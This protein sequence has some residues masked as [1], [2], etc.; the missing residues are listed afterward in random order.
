MRLQQKVGRKPA[1]LRKND[2]TTSSQAALHGCL[3][4]DNEPQHK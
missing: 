3:P 1:S 2:E 4:A